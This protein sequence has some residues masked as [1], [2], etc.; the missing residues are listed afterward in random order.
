MTEMQVYWW[1]ML[2]NLQIFGQIVGIIIGAFSLVVGIMLIMEETL[3]NKCYFKITLISILIILLVSPIMLIPNSKQYAMI[4]VFPKLAN[5]ELVAEMQED[6]PE[7][8][9]MAK[10]CMKEMLESKKG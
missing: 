2:D 1:L 6:V 4:K 10:E 3:G 5:S 9:A 7:M 8:Y